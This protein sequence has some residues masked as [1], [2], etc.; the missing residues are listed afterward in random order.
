M[1]KHRFNL[2]FKLLLFIYPK[3]WKIC[4]AG[5]ISILLFLPLD[6]ILK[7]WSQKLNILSNLKI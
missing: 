2:L 7:E 6:A 1:K 4:I 5:D 3:E